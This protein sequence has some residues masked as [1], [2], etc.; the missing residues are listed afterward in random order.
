MKFTEHG[1][2]VVRVRPARPGDGR[3]ALLR[4]EVS[5]TGIGIAAGAAD[6]ALPAVLAGRRSTTR[7]FGGT[8][9]GLAICARCVELMGGEIGVESAPGLGST[10]WF[11]VPL[12]GRGAE[13]DDRAA[14]TGCEGVRVLIVDD[15][16]DEPRDP[17]RRP[18]RRWQRE[19]DEGRRREARVAL[20]AARRRDEP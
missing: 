9:L 15:Q 1:E 16:A 14:A 18:L 5:D 13:R 7:R 6:R 11:T 3:A 2:V 8:G 19:G 20:I 12:E 4:F 10:F 17:A